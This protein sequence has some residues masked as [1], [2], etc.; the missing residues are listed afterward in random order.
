MKRTGYSVSPYWSCSAVHKAQ[1]VQFMDINITQIL[2]ICF[3]IVRLLLAKSLTFTL[4]LATL[5]SSHGLTIVLSWFQSRLIFL[6]KHAPAFTGIHT[7]SQ[8]HWYKV[9]AAR[10]GTA[11][12]TNRVM[13]LFLITRSCWHGLLISCP[14]VNP[15]SATGKKLKFKRRSPLRLLIHGSFLQSKSKIQLPRGETGFL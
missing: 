5:L 3:Y 4:N 15:G 7:T 11:L 14:L 2:H 8:P 9:A 13:C 6:W 10:L 12:W 1:Y